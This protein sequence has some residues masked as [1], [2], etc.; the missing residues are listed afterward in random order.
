MFASR[1]PEYLDDDLIGTTATHATD[2]FVPGHPLYRAIAELAALTRALRRAARR[3][4]AAPAASDA[5]GSTRSRGSTAGA[6]ASTSSRSTTPRPRRPRRSRPGRRAGCST[7]STAT[8]PAT[9]RSDAQ[10]RLRVTVPPL[11]AVVYALAGRIPRSERAPA[12]ALAEPEPAAASNGRMQVRADVGGDSFYEVAF[13][14]RSGRGG[15]QPIGT[16]DNAPYRVFHDVSGLRAGTRVEYRATVLDNARHTRRSAPPTADVPAPVLTWD[17]PRRAEPARQRAAA[18]VRRPGARDA[19]GRVRAPRGRR[20]LGGDRQDSSSP[21]YSITDDLAGLAPGT[22]VAYRATLTEPDGTT[23][24][25]A[26]R[27]IEVAPPPLA[28]AVVHY[29]R[30]AG[31]YRAGACTCGATRSTRPCW[32]ASRGTTRSTVRDRGRLGALRDRAARTTRRRSTSS[33]TSRAA[34]RADEP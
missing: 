19:R 18:A 34:T 13:E 24:T 23:V 16:D 27:T 2:N 28:K 10:R 20:R 4:P 21:A 32:P 11:S 5:P 29:L 22:A 26:V 8:A 7:G 14:A 9:L 12:I 33:C 3:R 17:A 1:T 6:S 25:S 31:D 30:P 15:W